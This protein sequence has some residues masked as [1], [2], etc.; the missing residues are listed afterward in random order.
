[1]E[2]MHEAMQSGGNRIVAG[3]GTAA[4]PRQLRLQRALEL[5]AARR[6]EVVRPYLG[7]LGYEL[8]PLLHLM[9]QDLGLNLPMAEIEH[10]L[11]DRIT[12]NK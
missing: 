8:L 1:M 3:E 4:A 5:L 11:H 7:Q 9:N 12:D 6:T 10:R 2:R